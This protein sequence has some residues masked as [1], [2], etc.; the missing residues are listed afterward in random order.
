M[1]SVSFYNFDEQVLHCQTPVL[2][3]FKAQWCG[4]CKQMTPILQEL[5]DE[6]RGK[7]KF[8][9]VD[10]NESPEIARRYN[11][12]AL[13]SFALFWQGEVVAETKGAQPKARLRGFI[14]R[15]FP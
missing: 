11:I 1:K 4:P 8:V 3:S 7:I 13:P 2:V 6:M 10:L 12:K 15:I 9:A 14:E 5:A